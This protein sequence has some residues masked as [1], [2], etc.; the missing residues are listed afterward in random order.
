M[1]EKM[2]KTFS[3]VRTG[4]YLLPCFLMAG[5]AVFAGSDRVSATTTVEFDGYDISK[6]EEVLKAQAQAQESTGSSG[7]TKVSSVKGKTAQKDKKGSKHGEA[8]SFLDG[9]YEGVGVGFAGHIKVK[10]VVEDSKILSIEVTEVEADD[11]P[12]VAKAKGVIESILQYQTIDV[13][14]VS[15]AT[16]SSKGIIAAVRNAL[17]GVEDTSEIAPPERKAG[18]NDCSGI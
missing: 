12:F 11:A 18:T 1:K 13:D 7:K 9:T 10:V 8:Q 15:G 2:K 4:C 14:T 5:G 16:Y 3:K 17:E 6:V